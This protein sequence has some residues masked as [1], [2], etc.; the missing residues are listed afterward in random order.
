MHQK[1]SNHFNDCIY[2]WATIR[3]VEPLRT[4]RFWRISQNY[5][6]K[7]YM[8]AHFM[9]FIND[10]TEGIRCFSFIFESFHARIIEMSCLIIMHP[11]AITGFKSIAKQT[12]ANHF[13]LLSRQTVEQETIPNSQ[14]LKHRNH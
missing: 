13:N 7:Y 4:N 5:P 1:L 11:H 10:K 14:M 3:L 6:P 12:S 9:P 8:H 2:T